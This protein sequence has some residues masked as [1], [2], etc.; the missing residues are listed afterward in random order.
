MISLDDIGEIIFQVSQENRKFDYALYDSFSKG[1][2]WVERVSISWEKLPYATVDSK[3]IKK[4][5]AK[6][7][8]MVKLH[9]RQTSGSDLTRT[10]DCSDLL[11]ADSH[12]TIYSKNKVHWCGG[13]DD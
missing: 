9:L 2:F 10:V 3:L 11:N 5:S 4:M 6:N 7:F 12:L 1:Y 8:N 13:L